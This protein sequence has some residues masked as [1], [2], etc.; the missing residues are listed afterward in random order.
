MKYGDDMTKEI[1][2]LLEGGSNRTDACLIAGISYETFTVWMQKPEFA[3]CI[4][5]AEAQFKNRNITIIQKAAATTW[6]AAAWLL[7]RKFWQEFALKGREE[8]P[9]APKKMAGRAAELLKEMEQRGS[10]KVHS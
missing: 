2:A 4:K 7:E 3:E 8:E 9:E 1:A 10:P 6:Q 5:K